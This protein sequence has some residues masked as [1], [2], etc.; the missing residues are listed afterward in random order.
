[1][2]IHV[3]LPLLHDEQQAAVQ[4]SVTVNELAQLLAPI[5]CGLLASRAPINNR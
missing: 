2:L 5:G 3:E 1:M 4:Y